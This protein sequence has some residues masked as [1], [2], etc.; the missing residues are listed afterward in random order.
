MFWSV[1]LLNLCFS[2]H[3][4]YTMQDSAIFI[5]CQCRHFRMKFVRIYIYIYEIKCTKSYLGILNIWAVHHVHLRTTSL[6][7]ETRVST[8]MNRLFIG[9][10]KYRRPC[11]QI[12][13]VKSHLNGK[14]LLGCVWSLYHSCSFVF[15]LYDGCVSSSA[16]MTPVSRYC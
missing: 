14:K 7:Y 8:H 5:M 13:S 1:I 6:L 2:I 9:I 12:I 15:R 4:K 10:F 3:I 11:T 16:H